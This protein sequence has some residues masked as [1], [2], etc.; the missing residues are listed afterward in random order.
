[1]SKKD[2]TSSTFCV[3]P[4]I[5][6]VV[7]PTGQLSFCCVAQSGGKI[8]KENGEFFMAA[9]DK[10]SDAWNSVAMQEIRKAMLNG[11]KVEAC[12]LCYF[13]ESIG[14]KSYREM[15]NDEWQEKAGPEISRRIEDSKNNNFKI[16][17][18][19][20]YL[21][22]RLGNLCNLKCRSCNPY[23]SSQIF[24][25]TVQLLQEDDEFKNVYSKYFGGTPP[26]TSPWFERD[27]FWDEVITAI[28]NIR[29]VYLTGGEPTLI[30]K[31]YKFL[32]ACVD[33]GHSK[34][35]FLMF[36]TNCTNI[37]D[38]FLDLLPHF[39][40]VLMNASIDGFGPTNDYIRFL[41]R[42]ETIDRN[43]QKLLQTKGNIKIGATP[44]IQIYN[45]LEIT[46][47]LEYIERMTMKYN[48]GISVDFLYATHPEFLDISNLPES[49]KKIALLRLEKFRKKSIAYGK[50]T[51][52]TN[53][54]DSC[55]NLLRSS[56]EKSHERLTDFINYTASLDRKRKQSFPKQ[57][58]ELH[59]LLGAEGYNL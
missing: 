17:V 56:R 57:F 52:I 1:M 36:N 3:Y 10:L 35:I 34:N 45:I 25:E 9:Q 43:F 16:N 58:P 59:S 15:H 37:Q 4:W 54:V 19:A 26:P 12:K 21:D 18:P 41:S 55:L 42:W 22:L 8:K 40:F 13:Q 14:K 32:N 48:K 47:L 6:Q 24:K 49:I 5:E 38:R 29:K 46:D 50:D 27:E 23:N 33:S 44:V 7:Q 39:E 31:N 28:P 20:L 11:E 51:F 30:E 2:P 53:S